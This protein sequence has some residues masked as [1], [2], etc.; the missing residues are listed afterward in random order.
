MSLV[1]GRSLN[2]GLVLSLWRSN[3]H[4]VSSS[5]ARVQKN[6]VSLSALQLN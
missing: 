6:D 4:S 3:L 1:E 2:N 5:N